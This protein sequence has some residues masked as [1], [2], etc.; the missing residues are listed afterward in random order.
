MALALM[1]ARSTAPMAFALRFSILP[2][3]DSIMYL[4]FEFGLEPESGSKLTAKQAHDIQ[5]CAINLQHFISTQYFVK[6]TEPVKKAQSVPETRSANQTET[7]PP[8]PR[9]CGSCIV[10]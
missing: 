6:E 3:I 8:K 1:F 7:A 5:L 2:L 9:K 4:A 10:F